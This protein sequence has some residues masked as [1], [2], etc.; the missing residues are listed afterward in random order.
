[1]NVYVNIRK[2]NRDKNYEDNPYI[3]SKVKTSYSKATKR[4]ITEYIR[5]IANSY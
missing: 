3:L 4:K 2:K 5:L 1:M